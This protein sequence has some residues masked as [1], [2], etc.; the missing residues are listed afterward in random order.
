MMWTIYAKLSGI[1]DIK[2]IIRPVHPGIT[3][4]YIILLIYLKILYQFIYIHIIS[5]M[6]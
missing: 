1:L 4:L 5:R 2:C 6:I 3:F